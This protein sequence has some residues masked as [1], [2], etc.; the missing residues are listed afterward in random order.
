[1]TDA[2]YYMLTGDSNQLTDT[3]I[4]LTVYNTVTKDD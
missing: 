3:R 2:S 1:M 4:M